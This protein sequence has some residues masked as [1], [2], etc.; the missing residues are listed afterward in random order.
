MATIEP[1]STARTVLPGK[2]P[3]TVDDLLRFPDDGNRYELFNG[4]LLVSP[5]PTP[6]HQRVIYRLQRMLDDA[7]PPELEPLST[8]NLR[9]SD[10][11]FYIPDLVIVHTDSVDEA[12]LMFA[13][14]DL[15]LAVEVGSPSTRTRDEVLKAAGYAAAGIPAYWRLELDEGPALY[16]YELDDD[17]YAPPAVYKAGSVA[18]LKTPFP[19]SFDPAGLLT[20]R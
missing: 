20:R 6:M 11:D 17:A 8:V 2:P 15:L 14:E 19:V 7:A 9:L 5:A 10:Q 18:H 4:S 13:P 12:E 3:F 16:V 1:I